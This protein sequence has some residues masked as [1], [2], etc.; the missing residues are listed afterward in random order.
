MP[1]WIKEWF[2]DLLGWVR[3]EIYA[4][5]AIFLD[6][7]DVDDTWV[8]TVR[9]AESGGR[10]VHV[11]GYV[12]LLDSL[13]I[14][15]L[16]IRHGLRD[17]GY[18][19]GLEGWFLRPM[20]WIYRFMTRH[21]WEVEDRAHLE[22]VLDEGR[23]AI[24]CLRTSPRTLHAR[25]LEIGAEVIGW[26]RRYSERTGQEIVLVP[27]CFVWGLRPTQAET[28]VLDVLFGSRESPGLLRAVLQFL[29]TRS[30][31][32]IVACPPVFLGDRAGE[33][34]EIRK[35]LV[36]SLQNAMRAV[37]GPLERNPYRTADLVLSDPGLVRE[38]ERISGSSGR[39]VSRVRRQAER[40]LGRLMARY[41]P[42]AVG[43]LDLIF[44]RVWPALY[45]SVEIEPPDLEAVK[46]AAGKGPLII[47]PTHR[48]HLDYLLLSWLFHHRSLPV[49][50]IAAGRNLSFFPLGLVFRS[51]GAFFIP[52]T[53]VGKDLERAVLRAYAHRIIEDSHHVEIFL[54]GTRSRSGKV[55]PMHTGLLEMFLER[56]REITSAEVHLLPA[57]FCYERVVEE[58]NYAGEQM[59]G[60]KDPE[61]L[62]GLLSTTDVLSSAYG[63]LVVRF[64]DPIPLRDLIAGD[65]DP[66]SRRSVARLAYRMAWEMNRLEALTPTGLLALSLLQGP[67][68]GSDE[69]QLFESAVFYLS[70]AR[71]ADKPI[72]P[73]LRPFVDLRQEDVGLDSSQAFGEF[74]EVMYRAIHLL[75]EDDLVS[76]KGRRGVYTVPWEKRLRLEYYRNAAIGSLAAPSLLCAVMHGPRGSSGMRVA[77]LRREVKFLSSVMRYEFIFDANRTFD[78]NF[79][80][81]LEFLAGRGV[82]ARDGDVALRDD[83]VAVGRIAAFVMP[84]I[85]TYRLVALALSDISR[86]APILTWEATLRTFALHD[87]MYARDEARYPESRN[88]TAVGLALRAYATIGLLEPHGTKSYTLPQSGDSSARFLETAARLG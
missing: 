78:E 31:V 70:L 73:V 48:S 74:K 57:A 63:R 84:A 5:F 4:F 7:V 68:Y 15:R 85:E 22:S 44:S 47:L 49:P 39:Q 24:L 33:D 34:A 26:L 16:S 52:R 43:L 87:R 55:M 29:R 20:R 21:G 80:T 42:T 30:S 69:R 32:T 54:E 6:R 50:Y 83:P 81:T 56:A 65:P 27:H 13:C 45:E 46:Q 2:R 58:E 41:N 18:V 88:R 35:E 66:G 86:K 8:K 37:T 71:A 59:G 67:F 61:G 23:S 72:S 12:H 3:K 1:F 19:Y 25:G 38:I 64:G 76:I 14:H 11:L 51:A 10:L 17:I 53:L 28:G 40:E 62:G 36:D 79:D 60:S 82:L 77:D 75:A 9:H